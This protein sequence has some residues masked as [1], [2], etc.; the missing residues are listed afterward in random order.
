M[1]LFFTCFHNQFR[2]APQ[3]IPRVSLYTSFWYEPIAM[4]SNTARQHQKSNET[5]VEQQ[6]F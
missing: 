2:Q 4:L 3:V 6:L 1:F 5:T